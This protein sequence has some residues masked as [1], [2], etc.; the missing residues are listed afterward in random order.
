MSK[1]RQGKAEFNPSAL[2]LQVER[3][4]RCKGRT[5]VSW[6]F[7]KG[8][9]MG[10]RGSERCTRGEGVGGIG[11]CFKSSGAQGEAGKEGAVALVQRD[12]LRMDAVRRPVVAAEW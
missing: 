4:G 7:L 3:V 12:D 1:A 8:E 2:F 5:Q 10:T 6:V 9:K 11:R